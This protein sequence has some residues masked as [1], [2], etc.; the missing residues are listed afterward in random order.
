MTAWLD[1]SYNEMLNGT[2]LYFE[3]VGPQDAPVLVFLHGGPGYNAYSFRDLVGEELGDY[4][5]VYL[6]QRGAGRSAPL[7]LDDSE[8]LTLDVFVNDL[9]A[10]REF[11]GVERLTPLGHGFGALIALEYGRRFPART[12]RVITVNPWIH[13]PELALS[14]L[15]NAARISGKKLEDPAAEVLQNT[16]EGQHPMVGSARVEAAFA[17]LNARDLLNAMQF[18]DAASR[19]RLEFADVESQLLGG[20]EVQQAFVESGLWEFEYP[21]FLLDQKRPVVV[22]SGVHD[23][24]S[25]P[26]QVEWLQDL[27]AAEVIEL[28]AGH[29][30]WVDD[31]ESFVAA[32]GRAMEA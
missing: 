5:V 11:L 27:A 6:D 23:R 20:A 31:L 25:Y 3:Q 28:D 30:P 4:R 8:P 13:M 24:T 18:V 9:E 17:A 7:E 12:E 29:Y 15:E 19:M 16:P 1:E 10:L 21:N 2:E 22:I 14:L 32:L 26:G